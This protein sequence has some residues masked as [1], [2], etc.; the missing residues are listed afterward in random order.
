MART[1]VKSTITITTGEP[2]AGKT[3]SRGVIYVTEVFLRDKTGI[4]Y[5]NLPLNHEKIA[6][7]MQKNYKKDY[8]EILNRLVKIS[9][10]ET[11]KWKTECF[12][13]YFHD[14]DL[15]NAYVLIDE[16]HVFFGTKT[17]NSKPGLVPEIEKALSE[18]RH[19]GAR[20]E[21]LTQSYKTLH[22]VVRYRVGYAIS[23]MNYQDY[24][25]VVFGIRMADWLQLLAKFKGFYTSG[26]LQ[27]ESK[28]QEDKLMKIGTR[29]WW[30]NSEYYSMYDSYNSGAGSKGADSNQLKDDWQLRSWPSL[31]V[32][33]L[34]RNFFNL[35]IGSRISIIS[36][37]LVIFI[38]IGP[39]TVINGWMD[40]LNNRFNTKK[41]EK[42][43]K[44]ENTKSSKPKEEKEIDPLL[45]KLKH[46]NLEK[47]ETIKNLKQYQKEINIQIEKN[48]SITLIDSNGILLK[49]G[50]Y[51]KIGEIIN[52]G[53]FKGK[54]LSKIDLEQNQIY[55]DSDIINIGAS[56]QPTTA[57]DDTK[58]SESIRD[59]KR[60]T[61]RGTDTKLGKVGKVSS[62]ESGSNSVNKLSE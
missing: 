60:D 42:M 39:K 49:E 1:D 27:T 45:E 40:R 14:K 51:I 20:L 31:I 56:L 62:G 13:K 55:I 37:C 22:T 25:D 10:E 2:G 29:V 32:W 21:L 47:D 11:E 15:Q 58:I 26:S 12:F 36:W 28:V 23:I 18:F 8:H 4:L 9:D 30:H 46:E 48:K 35:F 6:E 54:T 5:H 24:N 19:N 61:K 44:S 34:R 53:K 3:L 7:Y 43:D 59:E 52:Y 41:N 16:A 50:T 38:Y 57:T 17:L 33:F